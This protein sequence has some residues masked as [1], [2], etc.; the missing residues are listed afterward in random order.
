MRFHFSLFQLPFK[1][2]AD[3]PCIKEVLMRTKLGHESE[4]N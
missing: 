1:N 3:T 2:E 4:E